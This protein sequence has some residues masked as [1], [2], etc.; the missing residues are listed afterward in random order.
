MKDKSPE[1]KALLAKAAQEIYSAVSS[2]GQLSEIPYFPFTE[3]HGACDLFDGKLL[4][5]DQ[6]IGDSLLRSALAQG[7]P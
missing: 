1:K 4:E 7:R 5:H 6:S 2:R 3:A